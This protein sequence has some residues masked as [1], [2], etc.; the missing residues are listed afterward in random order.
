MNTSKI[1][2]LL[3]IIKKYRQLLFNVLVQLKVQT[4]A[5]VNDYFCFWNFLPL[6]FC[7]FIH[8]ISNQHK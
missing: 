3:P 7:I 8:E 5:Y 6:I 1:L 2:N 4:E